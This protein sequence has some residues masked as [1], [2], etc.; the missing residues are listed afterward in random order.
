MTPRRQD[1]TMTLAATLLCLGVLAPWRALPAQV[2]HDPAG[3]PYHD[4]RPGAGPV[5]LFGHLGG[6]RGI[7]GV[8]PSD[9]RTIGL[10]Y[11]LAMG[12][13][14]VF[15][16]TATYAMGDRF[17]VNPA[18]DSTSPDRR[19]GPFDTNLLLTELGVQLRLAGAKSWH[20]LAPY[21]GVTMGFAF[22]LSSPGDTT[23]SRYRFGTKMLLGA[24]GGVRWHP[25]RRLTVQVDGRA[26]YWRL[27]YPVSFH[28]PAPDESTIVPFDTKLFDWTMHPWVSLGVGWTF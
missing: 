16:F 3:S 18:V 8:G 6:D 9:A 22:D 20:G 12:R 1:A 17:I 26:L 7:A 13:P 23:Q 11:E 24:N 25:A 4:I 14:T 5:L 2:G 15:H 27:R 19:T 10:R 28:N 21:L